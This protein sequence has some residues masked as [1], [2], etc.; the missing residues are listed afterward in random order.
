MSLKRSHPSFTMTAAPATPPSSNCTSMLPLPG[1]RYAST[2]VSDT[3]N[4]VRDKK[5]WCL[6]HD[7]SVNPR[8]HSNI[9]PAQLAAPISLLL[10]GLR[11]NCVE[12]MRPQRCH[13]CDI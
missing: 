9:A 8:A 1:S 12:K 4:E 10:Y 7:I 13:L 2:R 5:N 3:Q 6:F 11:Y